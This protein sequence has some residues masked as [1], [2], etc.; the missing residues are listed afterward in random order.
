VLSVW[1]NLKIRRTLFWWH[2]EHE[3]DIEVALTEA[4]VLSVEDALALYGLGY[5]DT[6]QDDMGTRGRVSGDNS[7]TKDKR[8]RIGA[9][10][11]RK[12]WLL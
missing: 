6:Q 3:N 11:E 1:E 9:R 7:D 2:L 12:V 5:D 8:G 10:K 4:T